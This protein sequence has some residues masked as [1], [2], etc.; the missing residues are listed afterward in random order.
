MKRFFERIQQKALDVSQPPVLI[1]AFGDS[2]TQG[3][4]E[5]SRL[6]PESVYHHLLQRELERFFPATTFS[7][8][9][10]GVSG[11]NAAQGLERLQ[12][13]VIRHQPD[14]VLVAFG[15]NDSGLG[16]DKIPSFTSALQDTISDIRAGTDADILLL[17]PPFMASR[18]N[19]RIH[20]E[21]EA[22]ADTIIQTQLGGTLAH[23][24]Q[25]IRDLGEKLALPVADIYTEWV[26]LHKSGVDT[27]LWICNGL[28]HPDERGHRLAATLI[29]QKMLENR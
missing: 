9:N 7:T 18:R 3:C 26:R 29:F 27:T 17:T 14:L 5:H 22:L 1:V 23:Y 15:L 16:V 6:A 21:H 2:V 25:S 11:G 20:P 13:D 28:N 19:G 12:S 24:A 8:L 4:M 10:A